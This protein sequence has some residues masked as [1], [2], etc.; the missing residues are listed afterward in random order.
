MMRTITIGST[1]SVQGIFLRTLE[2]GKIAI[3]VGERT[4][5]GT[6]V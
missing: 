5:V 3:G 2:N 4:F 1:V 6:P